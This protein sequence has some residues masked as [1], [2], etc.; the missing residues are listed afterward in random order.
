MLVLVAVLFGA[1]TACGGGDD[2]A[3]ELDLSPLA[4]EGRQL[5]EGS[6]CAA[7]HGGDGRGVTGPSWV[8]LAGSEVELEDGSFIVADEAY[9]LRS[10]LDPGADVRAGFSVVMPANTLTE[11]DARAVVAYIEALS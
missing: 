3:A 2:A 8:G 4:E 7:C 9:L 11:D 10:I 6:G 5:V 1:L